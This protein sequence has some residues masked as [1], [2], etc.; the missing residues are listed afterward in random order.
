MHWSHSESTSHETNSL[1]QEM[2]MYQF[3]V[4]VR[5]IPEP[6]NPIDSP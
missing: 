3:D 2:K 1:L 6:S 5:L 4:P